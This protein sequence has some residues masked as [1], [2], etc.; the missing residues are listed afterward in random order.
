MRSPMA[1]TA[2]CRVELDGSNAGNA[3]GIVIA[4]GQSTVRGLVIN[5]FQ[6]DGT[7]DKGDA[8]VLQDAGGN[9]VTGNLLGSQR[10]QKLR[11]LSRRRSLERVF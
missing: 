2:S 11:Q 9:V 7:S 3:S 4:G 1:S 5:R 8:I 6:G 10:H